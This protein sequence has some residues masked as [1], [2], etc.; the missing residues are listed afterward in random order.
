VG[1]CLHSMGN[2]SPDD[3][4]LA[5]HPVALEQETA[6]TATVTQ[7]ECVLIW[8]PPDPQIRDGPGTWGRE[9]FWY[10]ILSIKIDNSTKIDKK[11]SLSILTIYSS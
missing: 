7:Y 4:A 9:W 8:T 11:I 5:I 3:D 2:L 10:L 1:C 6:V